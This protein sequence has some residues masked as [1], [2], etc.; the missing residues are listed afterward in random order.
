MPPRGQVVWCTYIGQRIQA[1]EYSACVSGTSDTRYP[2]EKYFA[3]LETAP[4]HSSDK[5]QRLSASYLHTGEERDARQRLHLP[6][7]LGLRPGQTAG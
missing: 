6:G 2:L 1:R 5:Y 3:R 7:E 4:T